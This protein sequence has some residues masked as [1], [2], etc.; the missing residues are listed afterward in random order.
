MRA[1]R[2]QFGAEVLDEALQRP[3][4]VLLVA[5]FVGLEPVAVVV[6]PQV[7]Q[8]LEQFGPEMAV[9]RD[10]NPLAGQGAGLPAA[11]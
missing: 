4:D 10:V 1:D 5:V 7:Q 8:K 3:L 6:L 9:Q 11:P 2:L